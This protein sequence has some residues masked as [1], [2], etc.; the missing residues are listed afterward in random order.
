MLLLLLLLV[1]LLLALLLLLLLDLL[2]LRPRSKKN[3]SHG[4][5]S[6]RPRSCCSL[7]GG[8]Q[9]CWCRAVGSRERCLEDVQW[10]MGG[11]G[12]ME[13]NPRG[14]IVGRRNRFGPG[15]A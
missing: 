11:G 15:R 14:Q 3:S 12:E 6:L 13:W 8:P 1:L 4:C 10:K 9:P 7:A 2:L 5:L